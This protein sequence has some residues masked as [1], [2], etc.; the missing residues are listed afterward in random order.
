MT[1][2]YD[3]KPLLSDWMQEDAI[4]PDDLAEILDQLPQTPQRRHRWSFT[5]PSNTWRNAS[6]FNTTRVAG[7]ILLLCLGA[8]LALAT[9]PADR[10]TDQAVLPAVDAP[11]LG[12]MTRFTI[13]ATE[14]SSPP[15]GTSTETA[16]GRLLEGQVMGYFTQSSD[17][18]MSG[19][20]TTTANGHL[21]DS[22]EIMYPAVVLTGSQVIENEAGSW[23][24]TFIAI[25]YPG[26]PDL[27]LQSIL[28]GTGA[29]EGLSAIIT[30]GEG[31]IFPGDLPASP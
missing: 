21:F 4:L 3:L 29:Y 9:A 25:D 7:T 14:S 1:I 19:D 31:L 2:D 30:N 17:P 16:F 18:R 26:T 28:T 11:A 10:S 5:F 23:V 12:D 15:G 22:E 6:M 13:S 24:G 8:G 20:M 27:H